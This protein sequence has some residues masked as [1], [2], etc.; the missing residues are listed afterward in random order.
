MVFLA[1]DGG[2]TTTSSAL[3][4]QASSIGRTS[5]SGPLT[6]TP[7]PVLQGFCFS[8][9]FNFGHIADGVDDT[10]MGMLLVGAL[11][12]LLCVACFCIGCLCCGKGHR[13]INNSPAYDRVK[14]EEEAASA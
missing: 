3:A 1:T 10:T 11:L 13:H 6:T 9:G 14:A 4:A 2:T 5:S 7:P 12:F 8:C